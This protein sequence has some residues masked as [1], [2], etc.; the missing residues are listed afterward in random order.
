MHI[1]PN[2][3]K[4]VRPITASYG[5]IATCQ[6]PTCGQGWKMGVKVEEWKGFNFELKGVLDAMTIIV[7]KR[8]VALKAIRVKN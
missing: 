7:G 3:R 2:C 6:C 1:C 4:K 8:R 5:R